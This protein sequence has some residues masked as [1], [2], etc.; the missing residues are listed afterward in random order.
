MTKNLVIRNLGP[1]KNFE[2]PIKK[3]N[4]FIGPQASGK[5]TIA[6]AYFLVKNVKNEIYKYIV[7]IK[8]EE[9]V[10]HLLGRLNKI[11][12]R[13]FIEIFG[14]T[15]DKTKNS[16]IEKFE[17]IYMLTNSKYIRFY[18]DNENWVKV[19][20]SNR[21]KKEIED[22]KKY[23]YQLTNI[24]NELK[25][26]PLN[27]E[28]QISKTRILSIL[29]ER[30]NIIFE[31][32]SS[33]TYIPAGRTLITLLGEHI[34]TVSIAKLDYITSSYI[35]K[36][37]NL[38]Q[39]FQSDL[40]TILKTYEKLETKKIDYRKVNLAIRIIKKILKGKYLVENGEERIYFDKDKYIKINY[41]S[42]GQQEALWI[43][44]FIYYEI[45]YRKNST[46]I[47]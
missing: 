42:S 36:M 9:D 16:N 25:N 11:L 7:N 40:E 15:K 21:L 20:Y 31:D 35:N 2:F 47:V 12:R 4:I 41:A 5:S 26:D 34:N 43:L 13:R 22:L 1:I 3:V 44:N 18:L 27:E 46:L 37:L 32:Y 29:L 19:E 38:K 39:L 45:L 6:K 23:L 28:K 10:K 8:T 24:Y 33:L 17:I 30:L 14:K